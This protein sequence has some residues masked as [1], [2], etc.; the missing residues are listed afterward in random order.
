MRE[1]VFLWYY[2][3]PLCSC[4]EQHLLSVSCANEWRGD[5]LCHGSHS[6]HTK[7]NRHT[8]HRD[9]MFNFDLSSQFDIINQIWLSLLTSQEKDLDSELKHGETSQR[10][11][12]CCQ[13]NIDQIFIFLY[14]HFLFICLRMWHFAMNSC[15]HNNLPVTFHCKSV[16][17]VLEI[18]VDCYKESMYLQVS[19]F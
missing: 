12:V 6:I 8:V 4:T 2:T 14:T 11:N 18:K 7:R 9:N 10:K 16:I 13:S 3:A 17:V 1:I 15:Q 19:V 5:F